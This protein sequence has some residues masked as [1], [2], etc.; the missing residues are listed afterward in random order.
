[1][2]QRRTLGNRKYLMPITFDRNDIWIALSEIFY[3]TAN[4][5]QMI[6]RT[7]LTQKGIKYMGTYLQNFNDQ[8]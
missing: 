4:A 3:T 7:F 8:K 6:G 1:M 2:D 5:S